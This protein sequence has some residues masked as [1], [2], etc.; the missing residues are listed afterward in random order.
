MTPL[1]ALK[2]ATINPATY[3]HLETTLGTVTVGKR[4][5]LVLLDANPLA[6]IASVRRINA[7]VL[8]GRLFKRA[9][10]DK[11]LTQARTAAAQ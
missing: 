5:D 11:L 9:D 6:D 4:A 3:L 1:A 10:L 2:T 8:A 7:V